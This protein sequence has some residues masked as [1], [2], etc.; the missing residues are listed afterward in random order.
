MTITVIHAI[1]AVYYVHLIVYVLTDSDQAIVGPRPAVCSWSQN[2][3]TVKETKSGQVTSYVSDVPSNNSLVASDAPLQVAPSQTR[4]TPPRSSTGVEQTTSPG[5]LVTPPSPKV[6]SYVRVAAS[7]SGYSGY[8]SYSSLPR[9]AKARLSPAPAS[10]PPQ[11]SPGAPSPAER[12]RSAGEPRLPTAADHVDGCD[13]VVSRAKTEE[14][15]VKD[16]R[17]SKASSVSSRP[18][19]SRVSASYQERR[20]VVE[21]TTPTT[22]NSANTDLSDTLE[23][24]T[25]DDTTLN[26]C[27]YSVAL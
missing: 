27:V 9:P 24:V 13:V 10:S 21:P 12:P 22:S 18:A 16:V 5:A 23:K 17:R 7:A 11:N 25:S 15:D 20:S 19:S 3:V 6:P 26:I 4:A 14:R 1:I 8:S 2:G